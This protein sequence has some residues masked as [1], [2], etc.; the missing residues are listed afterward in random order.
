MKNIMHLVVVALLIAMFCNETRSQ[1]HEDRSAIH[2]IVS[3][4][5]RG[6]NSGSGVQFAAP[7]AE[8][9]DYVV[10]NGMH[11]KGRRENAAGHQRIFDSIYKDSRLTIKIE[12]IRM[13]RSDVAIAHLKA[14]LRPAPR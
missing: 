10:V 3:K 9:S 4:L 2:A 14:V 1:S 8:N 5:E 11:L 6:W 13:L 12:N 7:F